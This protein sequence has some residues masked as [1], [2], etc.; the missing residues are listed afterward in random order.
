MTDVLRPYQVD[1]VDEI[2]RAI[3]AGE[4]RILVVAPTG[5]GKTKSPAR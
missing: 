2:E 3:A 4:R 1:V 5:S